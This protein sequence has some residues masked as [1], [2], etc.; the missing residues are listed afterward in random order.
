MSTRGALEWVLN[1]P[2]GLPDWISR[3]SSSFR[4]LSEARIWSKQAQSRAARP[5]PP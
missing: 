2:T 3:V 5:M 1:T 4:S